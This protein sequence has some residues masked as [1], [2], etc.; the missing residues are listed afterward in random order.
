[1]SKQ[2]GSPSLGSGNA[3]QDPPTLSERYSGIPERLLGKA[4]E[5]KLRVY[6]NQTKKAST[7]RVRPPAIPPDISPAAFDQAI[8]ELGAQIG[9]QHVVLNDQPLVD[10]W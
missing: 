4:R 1:M 10:G 3:L 7:E 5:S 9:E 8:R 6:E 2:G